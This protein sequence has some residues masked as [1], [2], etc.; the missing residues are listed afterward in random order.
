MRDGARRPAGDHADRLERARALLEQGRFSRTA[1]ELAAAGWPDVLGAERDFLEAEAWRGMG[2][3]H[4]AGRLYGKA[5]ARVDPRGDPALWIETALAWASCLRSLGSARRAGRLLRRAGSL[6]RSGGLDVFR[7]RLRLEGALVDR[8]LGRFSTSLK[9]LA[10]LLSGRLGRREW[11][12]AAFVLWAMGGALR[13]QGRFRESEAAFRRS[14]VLARRSGDSIGMGYARFG[15]GGVTRVMGRLSESARHYARAGAVFAG[16]ED[17][18]ARAYAQCGLANALRQMGRL[19]RAEAHYRKSLALY[20]R[21]EDDADLAYV[22]WG[23]GKVYLQRGRLGPARD[24]LKRALGLF[25]RCGEG[26]GEVLSALALAQTLHALGAA[27]RAQ[28]LFERAC[29]RARRGGL[30]A[31]LEVFT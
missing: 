23:L 18:F 2:F 8:A 30:Y 21:L 9:E 19:G 22:E 25:R 6:V 20:S 10:G 17:L 4:R 3:F 27:S 31:H 1:R 11:A 24:K 14:L 15:L 28:S 26:R 7:E 5:L 29:R 16:T 13:L 12:E